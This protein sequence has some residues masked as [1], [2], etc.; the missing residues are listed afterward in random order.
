MPLITIDF[1]IFVFSK[2]RIII[3]GIFLRIRQTEGI[4]KCSRRKTVILSQ[5]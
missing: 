1:Y 5:L 2:A 3:N 4:D